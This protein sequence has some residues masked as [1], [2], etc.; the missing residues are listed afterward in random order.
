MNTSLSSRLFTEMDAE[1]IDEYGFLD[2]SRT[3]RVVRVET[4]LRETKQSLAKDRPR[5]ALILAHELA[6]R[7][8]V[9][10][11]RLSEWQILNTPCVV[12][13]HPLR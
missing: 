5:A 9:S 3:P 13:M 11:G 8:H 12:A 1:R 2:L 10:D 6:C 4:I 7:D